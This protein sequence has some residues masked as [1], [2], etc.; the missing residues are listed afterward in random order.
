MASP[1][2]PSYA[3]SRTSD[4]AGWRSEFKL[5]HSAPGCRQYDGNR[6][7][8]QTLMNGLNW[9]TVEH[10]LIGVYE[11]SVV[12]RP[13]TTFIMQIAL[14][15]SI[16]WRHPF[17]IGQVIDWAREYSWDCI[18]ARGMSLG[19]PGDTE[20]ALNA[21][22]YDMLGPRQLR[23]TARVDLR[24]RLE[25]SGIQ[26]LGIYCSSPVNLPGPLGDNCRKVFQ[27]YLQLAADL[28][29]RWIRSIYN[30]TATH[31]GTEMSSDE[32]YERTVNGSQTVGRLAAE[33]GVGLLLENNENSVTPDIPSMLSLKQ[34]I[35]DVCSVG[36]TYDPVNAYFQ[37]YE[38]SE[39]F[40]ALSG[41]ID[42]L[43]VKNVRRHNENRWDYIPRGDFSYEWT[44]LADGDIDWPRFI[45]LARQ[46][47]FDGPVVYEYVNPFKGM[48]LSY[49][50]Q[51]PEPH[52]AAKT[53]ATSL[54]KWIG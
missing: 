48:P 26:L 34:D 19:I 15:G 9:M 45:D 11:F 5:A 35:G 42:V 33:L 32:A 6:P 18:D 38:P 39:G 51:L 30:S 49:W 25:E 2:W 17:G 16:A 27:E 50:D 41:Q 1:P 40:Q 46:A 23:A 12:D 10:E 29:A 21:F 13:E 20:R 53:E 22:G 31:Q 44:T 36:I 14:Y 7:S 54:R 37:G 3:R 24:R 8:V 43:H 52:L 47:D 28:G 4:S